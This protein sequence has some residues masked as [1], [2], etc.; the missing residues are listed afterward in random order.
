MN[1]EDAGGIPQSKNNDINQIEKKTLPSWLRLGP[2]CLLRYKGTQCSM[3]LP[4]SC[5]KWW[6]SRCR[7]TSNHAS[8]PA[9]EEHVNVNIFTAI[10]TYSAYLVGGFNPIEKYY[11]QTGNLPQIGVKK[12]SLKPPPRFIFSFFLG[13]RVGGRGNT[14]RTKV[15]SPNNGSPLNIEIVTFW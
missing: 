13:F 9:Q 3:T 11:S 5:P 10:K 6:W 14:W 2:Y 1:C 4:P 12:K 15:E 7:S 8:L